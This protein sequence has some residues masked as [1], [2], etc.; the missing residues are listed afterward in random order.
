MK[1]LLVTLGAAALL[2]LVAAMA[3]ATPLSF[4]VTVNTAPLI[5]LV[6]STGPFYLDFQLNDGSGTLAGANTATIGNFSFG[7]GA[8]LG[9]PTL[10]NGATGSLFSTVTLSDS[11]SLFNEFYQ[12]FTP[13]NSLSFIVTL[14][15]TNVDPGP[16]PDA[17]AFAILNGSLAN[18]STSG[19]GDVLAMVNITSTSLS[20]A[21]V[22]TFATVSPAG[23]AATAAAVPEPASLLLL[24]TGLLTLA[25]RR[26]R[27]KAAK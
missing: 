4:Q 5:P 11:A 10:L 16:T 15:P 9:A 7:G 27:G 23:V 20:A 3:T 17:F 6:G 1:R 26:R 22:Q 18:L 8:A 12:T 14:S 13:G 2:L 19:L 25:V 24:G 21:S